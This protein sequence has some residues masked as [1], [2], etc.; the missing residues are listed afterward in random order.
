MCDVYFKSNVDFKK[1]KKVWEILFT[2]ICGRVKGCSGYQ[3]DN[4]Y[5]KPIKAK[6]SKQFK[7]KLNINNTITSA[8]FNDVNIYKYPKVELFQNIKISLICVN[9]KTITYAC[10]EHEPCRKQRVNTI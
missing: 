5:P 7:Q 6:H 8:T 2:E 10:C 3:C 1:V 4:G 9:F